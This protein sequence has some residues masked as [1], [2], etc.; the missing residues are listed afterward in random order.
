MSKVAPDLLPGNTLVAE[1][2]E[3]GSWEDTGCDIP[4]RLM[5]LLV[6]SQLLLSYPR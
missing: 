5:F 6:D 1:G 3:R 2:V 4:V